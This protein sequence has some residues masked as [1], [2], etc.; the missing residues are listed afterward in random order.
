MERAGSEY[1]K[2]ENPIT[3][4]LVTT[5]FY[6]L[7]SLDRPQWGNFSKKDLLDSDILVTGQI[8]PFVSMSLN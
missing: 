5:V 1:G 7:A 2:R 6:N 4:I 8:S 3:N